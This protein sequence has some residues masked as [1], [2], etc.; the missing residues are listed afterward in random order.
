MSDSS[1]ILFSGFMSPGGG[2]NW[3]AVRRGQPLWVRA[4]EE[5]FHKLTSTEEGRAQYGDPSKGAT[6]AQAYNVPGLLTGRNPVC[7]IATG[8]PPASTVG[9]PPALLVSMTPSQLTDAMIQ[10]L[11]ADPPDGFP[12]FVYD[13][14]MGHCIALFGF[15]QSQNRFRYHDTWPGQS[16]L[17]K[18][19]NA[20]GVDAQPV[21]D[22]LWSVT[23]AEMTLVVFATFF[24]QQRWADLT[25][26]SY[27]IG[28]DDF[29]RSDF[30]EFF[31]LAESRR[32]EIEDDGETLTAID[33]K[34]GGFAEYIQ[35]R[36]VLDRGSS[37]RR[38]SL[39]LDRDW[40]VNVASG[41][42]PFAVDIAKSFIRALTPGPDTHLQKAA[43]TIEALSDGETVRA[44]FESKSTDDSA[45]QELQLAYLGV[46]E[47]SEWP[48]NFSN[49]RI[50]TAAVK[51]KAH[52]SVDVDLS[53]Y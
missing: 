53:V 50:T 34:T 42:N 11:V 24:S 44:L 40:I 5:T 43:T 1:E 8:R 4:F 35:L 32:G 36:I 33:L 48:S 52:V 31:H 7:V 46:I 20:A 18:E 25:G 27:R 15:D 22:G 38:G 23:K 30:W 37:I 45:D 49:L 28:Y 2:P 47:E 12:A 26:V 39:T 6:I 10:V 13:G 29:T 21:S 19:N 41:V 16:L 9:I 3:E 14:S 51:N 17:C